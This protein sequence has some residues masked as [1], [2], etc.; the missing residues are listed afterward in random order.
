MKSRSDLED[1]LAFQIRAVGLPAPIR[2][3]R[4]HPVRKWRFDFAYPE[5]G[6]AIEIHGGIFISGRHNRPIGFAK[7]CEKYSHAA[8][9][10]FRVLHFTGA[11]IK[12]GM[13]V[14]QIEEALN[15]SKDSPVTQLGL[16]ACGM[17]G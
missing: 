11:E 2:E 12:S 6:I 15:G 16:R 4:F 3:Y 5:K 7:D 9:A 13:A 8:L 14:N 10:G 17:G 1:K